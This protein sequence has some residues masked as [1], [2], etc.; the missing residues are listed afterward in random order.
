MKLKEKVIG[1]NYYQRWSRLGHGK[2]AGFNWLWR[3]VAFPWKDAMYGELTEEYIRLRKSDKVAHEKGFKV[4]VT[5]PGLRDF[6]KDFLGPVG[7]DEFYE[8]V[9]KT[10]AVCRD[11]KRMVGPLWCIGNELDHFD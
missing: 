9:M 1:L 10:C 7:S 2:K 6:N 4:M 5:T 3:Y 8:N 11:L